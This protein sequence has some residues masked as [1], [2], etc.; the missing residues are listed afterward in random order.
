MSTNQRQYLRFSLDIPA[1]FRS[2][3][4]E[5]LSTTLS[6]ISVGGCL[7]PCHPNIYPG[8]HFRLEVELPNGNRIPLSC[9]A[10]YRVDEMGIGAKFLEVTQFER[11]LLAMVIESKLESEDLPAVCDPMAAPAR[12]FDRSDPLR[13]TDR[14][15][16]RESL[17][18]EVMAVEPDQL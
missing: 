10:I 2:S 9:K 17:L 15:V 16:V 7:M 13:I 1:V 6:Q 4:G 12:L 14:I 18:E 11:E 5:K 3:A 8:D